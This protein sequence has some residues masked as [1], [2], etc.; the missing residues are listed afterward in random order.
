MLIL[1]GGVVGKTLLK[2]ITKNSF[3]QFVG[4]IDRNAD[5]HKWDKDLYIFPEEIEEYDYDYIVVTVLKNQEIREKL[6]QLNIE[7][8]KVIVLDGT[9]YCSELEYKEMFNKVEVRQAQLPKYMKLKNPILMEK[10]L[11]AFLDS[12]PFMVCIERIVSVNTPFEDVLIKSM[13]WQASILWMVD[14]R[15]LF[16]GAVDIKSDDID[17]SKYKKGMLMKDMVAKT[18]MGCV[19][20]EDTLET[21]LKTIH[22]M[23]NCDIAV[24]NAD[25]KLIKVISRVSFLNM[26]ADVKAQENELLIDNGLRGKQREVI[27]GLS[28]FAYSK[29]SQCGEDGI[30][31]EIFKRIG[32]QSRY[33]VEFGGWDGIYLSNIRN[34]VLEYGFSALYIEGDEEKAAEGRKN[35]ESISD[36]VTFATGFVQHRKEKMLDTFL[37]ENHVPSNIDLLSIDIDGYDY[38][39]WKSL[40]DYRP[41]CVVIEYNPTIPNHML[42][43]P[44]LNEKEQTGASA[45]ALVELGM[46]KGYSLVAVTDCNLIFV[47]NEEIYKLKIGNTSLDILRPRSMY[48]ENN[49]FMTYNGEIYNGGPGNSYIWQGEKKFASDRFIVES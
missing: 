43:V 47:V 2:Q 31:E 37:K 12:N 38:H 17:L 30:I 29:Y 46:G 45:R 8:N 16:M 25:G 44:P 27:Q 20:L 42:V 3:C 9:D 39:V 4:F 18:D 6:R 49:W 5:E 36:R 26:V 33:A 48:M 1:W 19:Y 11:S 21:V 41:R 7:D 35:Y 34:L 40:S 23:A 24:L 14:D 15:G 22:R 10:T 32:F 28:E 13:K